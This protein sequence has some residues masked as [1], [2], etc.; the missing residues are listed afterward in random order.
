MKPL[1]IVCAT[2]HKQRDF[3][4]HTPLGRSL[5][6]HQFLNPLSTAI[7]SDH[8][9][10]RAMA[11]NRAI[12]TARSDPAILV[13]VHDDVHL[14]DFQWQDKIREGVHAYDVMGV[15]GNVRV[16]PRHT[17]W[18]FVDEQFT[19]D[20]PRNLSGIV[21]HGRG[22]PCAVTSYGAPGKRVKLLDG[23]LLAADS[24]TLIENDLR[25]DERLRTHFYDLDFCL[26]ADARGLA[27]GTWPL[28]VVQESPGAFDSTAW[29]EDFDRYRSKYARR[30]IKTQPPH[31]Q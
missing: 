19:R 21:G 2:P 25:F 30:P 6:T 7:Y 13:F 10:T 26:Q 23:F 18:S 29:R 20:D 16:P 24:E 22:F 11:Y 12:E 15:V 9:L 27:L 31:Q 5:V 14:L 8:K 3:L 17:G 1:R 4:T 28:S